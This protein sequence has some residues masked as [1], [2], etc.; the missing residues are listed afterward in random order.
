[1]IKNEEDTPNTL[2]VA[3]SEAVNENKALWVVDS[4]CTAHV[5]RRGTIS[6]SEQKYEGV[7]STW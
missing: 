3:S 2:L 5:Q 4:G 1:M 7:Y 6:Q